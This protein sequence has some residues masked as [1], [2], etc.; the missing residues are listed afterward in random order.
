GQGGIGKSRLV[1]EFQ[2]Y[3]DGV[4]E[5]A[6]WHYGRSPAYGEGIS[7]WALAEMVRARAGIVE[8][9]EGAA[10]RQ[11]LG[12]T[13]DQFVNDEAERRWIEP[14][15]LHLLG[16]EEATASSGERETL[17]AAWR[18]FFERIAEQGTVV[19]VFEDLQW[20]DGGLL[21]F[22]DHLL[23]WSR[24]RPLYLISL[25]RPE[26]LDRRQ[27]WG[28][29]RRNFTSLVL[30]P[31]SDETMRDLL[32]GLVPGLGDALVARIL[33]RA[34]GIPL[35]AVETV[36]ML[37]DEERIERV[38]ESYRLV[39]D[40][41]ELS[42]PTTLQ[43]LIAARLDGLDPADRAL[44]QAASVMGKTFTVD[45]LAEISGEAAG[46][47]T[48]RLRALVRR[49]LVTLD[50]DPRS[51]ERG[52]YG[53]VQAMLREVAYGGLARRD[54]RRLHLAAA[55]FFETLDD[56]GLAAVLAE[57]YL[58]AYR[59]HP[60]GPEG[61]AVAAQARVA[62]RGAA[63]RAL[64][65]GSHRQART[66][67]EQALEVTTDPA[68][69]A[70]LHQAAGRAEG[71]AA[72]DPRAMIDHFTGALEIV[73]ESGDRRRILEATTDLARGTSWAHQIGE[74]VVIMRA[75]LDEIVDLDG[76]TE[77]VR[78]NAE[79][80][81]SEMMLGDYGGSVARTEQVLPIAERLGLTRE[82]LEVLV[83]RGAALAS[84]R[85]LGEAMVVLIGAVSRARALQ[86]P[87]LELR[88]RVNL[89]YVT[90][91][92]DPLLAYNV[93]REGLELARRLGNRGTGSYLLNNASEMAMRVGE[94]D[95]GLAQSAEALAEDPEGDFGAFLYTAAIS[96]Y[97]GEE[98]ES[99]LAKAEELTRDTTEIQGIAMVED[100]RS[101]VLLAAG[102]LDEARA[103]SIA[104]YIRNDAPDS[105]AR[106]R[107]GRI[108]VWLADLE[109]VRGFLAEQRDVPG[110]VARITEIE[111]SAGLAALEGR[112]P[113]ATGGY[114][115]A[116][117]R[118]RELGV[119]FDLAMCGLTMVRVLGPGSPE[120]REAATEAREIFTSL[121][122]KALLDLLDAAEATGSRREMPGST[123]EVPRTKVSTQPS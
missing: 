43:A 41:A 7:F 90:S 69:R 51:P 92:E 100:V 35:Y 56:E 21:D 10:A 4:T 63:E 14:H 113:D 47:L 44:L 37:L 6:Y 13:L 32:H 2:K 119:R 64:S 50:G 72:R 105:I 28:A 115:E 52:Q 12:A 74:A 81:R 17:F 19:L 62:L 117:A 39:G 33:E 96:A 78:L 55:R 48:T 53:F 27:D 11:K 25:A 104:S 46:P 120:A 1:W 88:G 111:L 40:L 49:E 116:A 107:A 24:D 45:A 54:R 77:W 101:G 76:T 95:W 42:V 79:L 123:A 112:K 94:W 18:T 66:Y 80:A 23:D 57:H 73:K 89:S 65:L 71:Q 83:T 91:A 9:E 99:F 5:L 109:S 87:S 102:R 31:L 75:A 61:E 121:R 85:R 3:L 86:L 70:Q 30:E 84:E 68:E 22:I 98:S 118:W 114:R 8:G 103:L 16:F 122:A 110:R 59:A 38:G 26:L 60:D 20:A 82:I 97:R 67:F 36:R 29:G 106:A 15:L 108:S 34:E 93:A 58:A